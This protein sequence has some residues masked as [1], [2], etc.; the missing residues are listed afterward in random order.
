MTQELPVEGGCLPLVL[1]LIF[2]LVTVG[3]SLFLAVRLPLLTSGS[4]RCL[5]LHFG[6]GHRA[7]LCI[8][9]ASKN[10]TNPLESNSDG[11]SLEMNQR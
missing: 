1:S 6:D 4:E 11:L 5:S 10:A 3:R 7:D 9:N 8:F 2:E